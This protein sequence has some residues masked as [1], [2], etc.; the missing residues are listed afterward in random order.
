MSDYCYYADDA[1]VLVEKSELKKII[2]SDKEGFLKT[3]QP[4]VNKSLSKSK[5]LTLNPTCL[6]AHS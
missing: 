4:F 5:P 1:L 3:L 2:D 6:L